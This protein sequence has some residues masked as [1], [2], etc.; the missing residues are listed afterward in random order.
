VYHLYRKE[1]VKRVTFNKFAKER[2]KRVTFNKFAY[3]KTYEI[4]SS[5]EDGKMTNVLRRPT[6]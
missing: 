3:V 1:R 2:V 6:K 4:G 5:L